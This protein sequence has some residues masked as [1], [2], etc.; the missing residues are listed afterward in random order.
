MK[1]IGFDRVEIS[2]KIIDELIVFY[3]FQLAF[4]Q[5]FFVNSFDSRSE[6]AKQ[7]LVVSGRMPFDNGN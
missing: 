4:Q 6:G 5:I 3:T 2:V 1:E 7:L